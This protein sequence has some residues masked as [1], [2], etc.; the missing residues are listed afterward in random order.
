M[1][2]YVARVRGQVYVWGSAGA[3]ASL[4]V[5]LILV[6]NNDPFGDAASITSESQDASSQLGTLLP[7]QCWTLVL[8]GLHGVTATCETDTTLACALLAPS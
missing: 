5:P 1:F 8:T 4:T 2:H 3:A 7:G 6:V